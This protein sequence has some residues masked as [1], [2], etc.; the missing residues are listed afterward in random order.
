MWCWLTYWCKIW[1]HEKYGDMRALAWQVAFTSHHISF[2]QITLLRWDVERQRNS[3]I[4]G[5]PYQAYSLNYYKSLNGGKYSP[6]H[7]CKWT[8]HHST[9]GGMTDCG[10]ALSV[11]K[12]SST[13]AASQRTPCEHPP[14]L[15]LNGWL[16]GCVCFLYH[17]D[18]PDLAK[19]S[20]TCE[21]ECIV[22]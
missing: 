21:F 3:P 17:S 9:N 10:V 20:G 13:A 18:L 5:T 22:V 14:P 12:H 16:F 4:H 11:H 6:A 7:T 15:Y 2:H 19:A 8:M 1:R